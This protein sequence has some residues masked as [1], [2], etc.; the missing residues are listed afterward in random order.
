[1]WTRSFAITLVVLALALIL[2]LPTERVS[3]TLSA[4]TDSMLDAMSTFSGTVVE[5]VGVTGHLFSRTAADISSDRRRAEETAADVRASYTRMITLDSAFS[6]SLDLVGAL[7][8]VAVLIIGG[9][10]VVQGNMTPA[11]RPAPGCFRSPHRPGNVMVRV[12]SR[13]RLP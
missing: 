1:M 5:R 11:L 10:S 6:S 3:R 12:V 4:T 9:Y 13:E 7:G 2:T 8:T